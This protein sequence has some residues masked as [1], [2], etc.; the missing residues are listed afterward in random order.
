MDWKEIF[1]EGVELVLATHSPESGPHAIVVMS[2][3][4]IGG[5]LLVNACQTQTTLA[6]LKKDNRISVVAMNSGK[7]LRLKGTAELHDSGKIFE[8]AKKR[9]EGTKFGVKCAIVIEPKEIF[10]LDK[11][12][13]MED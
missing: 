10:D 12:E 7:Y 13:V 1:K 9:N 8:I 4:F 5:K 2:E 11:V 6:N 3:G